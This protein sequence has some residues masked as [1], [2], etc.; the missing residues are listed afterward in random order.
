MS[1]EKYQSEKQPKSVDPAFF[2]GPKKQPFS[3]FI[4]NKREGTFLGRNAESW[5]KLK[6]VNL[7]SFFL[8]FNF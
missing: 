1:K 5:S 3:H 6:N 7:N 8:V 4:Y 2:D